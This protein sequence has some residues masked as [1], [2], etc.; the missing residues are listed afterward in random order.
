M[1]TLTERITETEEEE[2]E[3]S[4]AA[5][6]QADAQEGAS[7]AAA[8]PENGGGLIMP[9]DYAPD[10][11]YEVEKLGKI[12]FKPFY[13]FVKRTFDIVA[14]LLALVALAIPMI[15]IA[16]AI[17]V[18]SPGPVIYKQE[19]LGLNGRRFT[20]LKFRSMRQDAEAGGAMWSGGDADNRI[21][22]IGHVLRKF[23]LDELPQL[24]CTLVGTMTL[25]GPRPERECFYIEF[26]KHVHGFSERLKVRP[27]ITGLA[28]VHGGYD[29]PPHEKV[30]W[31]IEYIKKR[32]LHADVGILFRTVKIIFSHEG[33]K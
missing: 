12:P 19:R 20:I 15:I 28:Q 3:Q 23:R 11:V 4:G 24:F 32:S 33:A 13:S 2:K 16:I 21:T 1:D 8:G 9:Y 31:D 7:P 30:K 17:R 14:S 22:P 29:L 18:S 5:D 26:E 10:E 6:V 27:G 25:V